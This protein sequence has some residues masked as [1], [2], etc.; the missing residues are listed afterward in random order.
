MG[1]WPDA[2]PDVGGRTG[3][4]FAER[5]DPA[6]CPNHRLSLRPGADPMIDADAGSD[7]HSGFDVPAVGVDGCRGGWVC[8]TR[9]GHGAPQILVVDCFASVL[10]RWPDA[11]IAVD[12]PIGL[13]RAGSRACDG[14]ARS[15]LGRR[16]SSVFPAPVRPALHARTNAEASAL[17][18][19]VDGRGVS[20][21]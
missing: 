1:A 17:H 14:L 21:Q 11:V 8:V 18:R 19:A 15:R 9:L 6:R 10:D 16:R 13:P 20:A 12:M 2:A 7:I 4:K 3:G 5:P